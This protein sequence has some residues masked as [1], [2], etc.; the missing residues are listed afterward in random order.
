[1]RP[2]SRTLRGHLVQL[3]E[4]EGDVEDVVLERVHERTG[5][6]VAHLALEQ[7]R[8]HAA[9][10]RAAGGQQ[11]GDL[12]PGSTAVLVEPVAQVGPGVVGLAPALEAAQG[13]LGI[14]R[15]ERVRADG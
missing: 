3:V 11:L 7:V 2:M 8:P 5:A 13:H 4:I 6:T 10:S 9:R 12:E 15:P 1:M 14:Q